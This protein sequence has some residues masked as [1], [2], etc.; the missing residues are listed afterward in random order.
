MENLNGFEL[1]G[2]PMKVGHVTERPGE[3]PGPSGTTFPTYSAGIS[4]SHASSLDSDDLDHRGISLG[5][6]WSFSANG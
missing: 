4:S 3:M 6:H 5:A 1:A 2:R